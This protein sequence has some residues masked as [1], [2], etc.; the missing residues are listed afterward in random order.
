MVRRQPCI[1][2][3]FDNNNNNDNNNDCGNHNYNDFNVYDDNM[4]Y[5]NGG[6]NRH[7]VYSVSEFRLP[8]GET[9]RRGAGTLQP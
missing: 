5:C 3:N 8:L 9:A 2:S 6:S 4:M 1:D 7:Q